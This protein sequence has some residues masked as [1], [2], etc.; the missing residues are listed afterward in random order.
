M[1][2]HLRDVAG[3]LEP[4]LREIQEPQTLIP[5]VVVLAVGLETVGRGGD[6]NPPVALHNVVAAA[7]AKARRCA[8]LPALNSKITTRCST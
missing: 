5:I 6:E 1:G 7:L 3:R 2:E 4:D 8:W